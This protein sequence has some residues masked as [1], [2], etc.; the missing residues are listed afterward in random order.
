MIL[1]PTPGHT[2][3]SISMLIRQEGWDPILLVADLT[4]ET[5]LMEKDVVPGVG[6]GPTLLASFAKVRK[7]KERL[8]NLAIVPSHDF[9]ASEFID[10]ATG[11]AREYRVDTRQ[12]SWSARLRQSTDA[13]KTVRP[14][15]A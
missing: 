3:G 6:D 9:G 1:L 4:Y 15:V 12:N 7:L 11:A 14:D 2:K 8:P 5:A 10:Q 13:R